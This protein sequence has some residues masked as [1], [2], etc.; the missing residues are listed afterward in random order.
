MREWQHI[1]SVEAEHARFPS[2]SICSLRR[3]EI[4]CLRVLFNPNAIGVGERVQRMSRTPLAMRLNI[5]WRKL[6]RILN[7]D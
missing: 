4:A 1:L 5:S 3:R 7:H 2:R 6:L